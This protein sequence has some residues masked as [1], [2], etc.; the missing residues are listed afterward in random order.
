MGKLLYAMVCTVF[1]C[2]MQAQRGIVWDRTNGRAVANASIS[3]DIGGKKSVTS[4]DRNGRF[5][6][7]F[8]FKKLTVSHICYRKKHVTSLCDTIFLEPETH[9][10]QEISVVNEEKKWIKE[11]LRHFIK[12]RKTLYQ[13]ADRCMSY[14]YCTT[15]PSGNRGY[16]FNSRGQMHVPSLR[17][18]EKDSIYRVCPSEN[19]VYSK[20]TTANVDFHDMQLML[21]ENV[22]AEMD[23]KFL[24]RHL[25]R[26]DKEHESPDGNTVRLVFRSEKHKEDRGFIVMDTARCVILE[27]GRT[28]GLECNLDEK[29]SPFVLTMLNSMAGLRFSGWTID[30]RIT[31]KEID[32]VYYPAH[33]TYRYHERYSIKSKPSNDG[34][35]EE[36]RSDKEATLTL[37]PDTAT[38]DMSSGRYYDIPHEPHATI[39]YIERKRHY[40][41][42]MAMD[43]MPRVYKPLQDT[44]MQ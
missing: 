8:P 13:T 23:R 1:C 36:R 10:I 27:A 11:K 3:T 34:K 44:A 35:H 6:V 7:T 20:D 37:N 12:H 43:Q 30:N 42:R 25:F 9:E 21:Y 28:T 14:E 41:N 29:I 4:S 31:F 39:I 17:N 40:Q 33:I 22:I 18:M 16:V 5:N 26:E 32:N 2:P 15:N 38:G 19:I 24:R